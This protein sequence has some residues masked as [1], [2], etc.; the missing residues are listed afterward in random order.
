MQ[1][2]RRE[3]RDTL[4]TT[5]A[6]QLTETKGTV[7]ANVCSQRKIWLTGNLSLLSDADPQDISMVLI[8][9]QFLLRFLKNNACDRPI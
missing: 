1:P 9:L 6:F 2:A 3:A 5:K 4:T 8:V 7:A